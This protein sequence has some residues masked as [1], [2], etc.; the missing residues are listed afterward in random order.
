MTSHHRLDA[1]MGKPSRLRRAVVAVIQGSVIAAV[2]F[3]LFSIL[4]Y[5]VV[6][7]AGLL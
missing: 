1:Q 6:E 2:Y 7:S 5:P 3:G 4:L